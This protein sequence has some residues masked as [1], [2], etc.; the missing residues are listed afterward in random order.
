MN[1]MSLKL[2]GACL[3]VM[4]LVSG[5]VGPATP[6]ATTFFRW[7]DE[8]KAGNMESYFRLG[9]CQTCGENEAYRFTITKPEEETRRI[10]YY[11]RGVKENGLRP[12]GQK[13]YP[14]ALT[15][16]KTPAQEGYAPAMFHL[17][18]MYEFG[19]GTPV[20]MKEAMVWYQRATDKDY[21]PA[22]KR[23]ALKTE[24]LEAAARR[25]ERAIAAD[26]VAAM[27]DM[28]EKYLNGDGVLQNDGRA[29]YWFLKAAELGSPAAQGMYGAVISKTNKAEAVTWY[30]KAAG[31]GD[32]EAQNLLGVCYET[33]KG[34]AT[35]HTEAIRW[36]REAAAAGQRNAM[37]NLGYM[38][39]LGHGIDRDEDEALYWLRLAAQHG[40]KG[41]FT[42]IFK[43]Y[44]GGYGVTGDRE[45]VQ[46]LYDRGKEEKKTGN[47][48]EA[49]KWYAEAADCDHLFAQTSLAMLLEEG[50]GVQKDVEEA[51]VW[52]ENA[53][54]N[55]EPLAQ[56]RL[57]RMCQTGKIVATDEDA[58]YWYRMAA[59]QGYAV[60]QNNLA[61]LYERGRGVPKSDADALYWYGR[62]MASERFGVGTRIEHNFNTA[63]TRWQDKVR[64]GG[65]G[66]AWAAKGKQS[67]EYYREQWNKWAFRDGVNHNERV[68][69]ERQHRIAQQE[70]AMIQSA[71]QQNGW[72]EFAQGLNAMA[73]QMADMRATRHRATT[74]HRQAVAN[75]STGGGG[76]DNQARYD[77]LQGKL[78]K[79][80]EKNGLRQASAKGK[81]AAH[82]IA[83]NLAGA[84]TSGDYRVIN[85]S[86]KLQ[87]TYEREMKRL[88]N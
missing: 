22:R 24:E 5:C 35:N 13:G 57:A 59:E 37:G 69:N 58:V 18:L 75:Y 23:L 67:L 64:D 3:L 56:F 50:N 27:Y 7:V 66:T 45:E 49:A 1:M 43:I 32:P 65:E 62:A 8:G 80:N 76:Y 55:G 53:A 2:S 51:A 39:S 42:A 79:E 78:K 16:F 15:L 28:G 41:A 71:A 74:A 36:Y 29:A 34:I 68:M 61:T 19:R 47:F 72:L 26:D 21:D 60:A 48:A 82:A 25:A 88:E 54:A 86:K 87:R 30:L 44:E 83:P 14:N 85:A 4:V 10:G 38:Y 6:T 20:D 11:M 17:A 31:A 9:M 12:E 77:Q 52:L 81:A 46:I 63:Y 70:M 84:A 73:G 33:G 40:N